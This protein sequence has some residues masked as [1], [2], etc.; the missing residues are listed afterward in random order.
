[1]NQPLALFRSKPLVLGA[2]LLAA[3][4][5]SSSPLPVLAQDGR[6]ASVP[7]HIEPPP[8]PPVAAIRPAPL[9]VTGEAPPAPPPAVASVDDA[10]PPPARAS[11]VG[12]GLAGGALPAWRG[13]AP[14]FP[15]SFEE[16]VIGEYRFDVTGEEPAAQ[17]RAP[18][19]GGTAGDRAW[20]RFDVLLNWM[21]GMP[22]PVLATSSPRGVDP[23]LAGVL[24]LPSTT[25]LFGGDLIV[26]DYRTGVD[27]ELG[28]WL[29]AIDG[30]QIGYTAI[31]RDSLD[32][33]VASIGDPFLGRPF[34][35]AA[36][37]EE[38]PDAQLV[39]IP[40]EFSGSI[41]VLASAEMEGWEILYRR[42]MNCPPKFDWI[43]GWRRWQ[44]DDTL[45][46]SSFRLA[47]DGSN[48]L[49]A[50][51]TL[52][53]SD[54][55]VTENVF[56]GLAVGVETQR[57][58][59]DLAVDLMIRMALGT[60]RYKVGVSGTS[61]ATTFPP[62]APPDTTSRGSGLLAQA[63]NSGVFEGDEFTVIPELGVRLSYRVLPHS[64][65]TVGYSL[66]YWSRVARAGDQIDHEL[67]LTQLLP[68]GLMGVPR[69]LY[70]SRITDVWA[71]GVT[72]GWEGRF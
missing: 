52:A 32:Y 45:Q 59:G 40:N 38:G 34:Y 29:T 6:G 9:A 15:A 26:G 51:S 39:A 24:G 36:P 17:P 58:R 18:M 22:T 12:S 48:G 20:A 72:L 63:T 61:T 25:V 35:N 11:A 47:L 28:G 14:L 3:S 42:R 57:A 69:P 7:I 19:T 62:G 23:T 4:W 71:Q 49:G 64:R 8:L 67:N 54:L 44:L 2:L 10:P 33:T 66:V 27:L 30:V 1:M 70:R 41:R 46:V 65:L 37:G 31:G 60:N 55:F 56:D 21:K 53:E 16:P 50:G 68:G 13:A 43:V 5:R